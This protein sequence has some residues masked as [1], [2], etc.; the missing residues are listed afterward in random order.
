MYRYSHSPPND[1]S[2]VIPSTAAMIPYSP[3][4]NVDAPIVLVMMEGMRARPVMSRNEEKRISVSG[5]QYVRISFGVPG[6]RK[7]MNSRP[8]KSIM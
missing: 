2:A 8:M 5:M 4:R 7:M 6:M 3:M 1:R